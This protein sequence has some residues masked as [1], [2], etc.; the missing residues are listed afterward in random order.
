MWLLSCVWAVV[1]FA[2]A[3]LP[4][5]G[6]NAANLTILLDFENDYSPQSIS[7]M[8]HESQ[9]IL[10]ASGVRLDWRMKRDVRP[11]DSFSDFVV[12]RFKGHC[13]ME[14]LPYLYDERGPLA[15]THSADGVVLPFSE[16]A[17]DKVRNSVRNALWGGE[18]NRAAFLYG[19]A[20]GRV[21]AHEVYHILGG[22]SHHSKQGVA[23]TSL[24][25]TQLISDQLELDQH[26]R[27]MVRRHIEKTDRG[28]SAY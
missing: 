11:E 19:R 20:L 8:K 4:C 21:L 2:L 28:D 14:P 25:G 7:E 6:S 15:F 9:V 1:L 13:V 3:S 17:C 12:V 22:T 23:K 24:S 26:A 18:R 16:V 5:S 27:D 10:E